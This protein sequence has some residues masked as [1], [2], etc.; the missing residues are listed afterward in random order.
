MIKK[1][2]ITYVKCKSAPR[3]DGAQIPYV[4]VGV[5]IYCEGVK[6]VVSKFGGVSISMPKAHRRALAF[7]RLLPVTKDTEF[8]DKVQGTYGTNTE[9]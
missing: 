8:V 4:A 6:A 7:A 1:I 9:E 2:R 3:D 5:Y